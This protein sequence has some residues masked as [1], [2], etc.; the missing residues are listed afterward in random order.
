MIPAPFKVV[1]DACVLYPFTVRDVLLEAAAQGFYQVYWSETILD[2]ALRNL[3]S[4][5]RMTEDQAAKLVAV[6]RRA[7][8]EAQV[9]DYEALIPAMRN[10]EKDR[11]VAAAAVKAGAQVIVTSNTRDFY[12]LPSG[13]DVQTPDDFLCNLFDL[14]P[15]HM[16][17][18]LETLAR[19][20]RKPPMEIPRIVNALALT[21][22]G[23]LVCA[24]LAAA[25][26]AR[27]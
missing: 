24:Q 16:M 15:P 14:D 8:P 25:S 17:G 13:I 11:H 3:I 4:D 9:T 19:R 1:L 20:Y 12:D 23:E 21:G 18:V 26:D 7:F 6:M 2:E 5:R 22:F 27:R 10:D